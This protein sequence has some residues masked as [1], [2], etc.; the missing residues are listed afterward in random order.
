MVPAFVA[1]IVTL[2]AWPNARL[3]P[4]D[5]PIGVAGE[6]AAAEAVEQQLATQEGAF[7]VHRY[8]DEAEAREAIEDRDVY[9]A[10]V[11]TA[12]G[13]T[14]LTASAA[15]QAVA[16][17]L[18]HEAGDEVYRTSWRHRAVQLW[19]RPSCRSCSREY[20]WASWP[21]CWHRAARSDW[22]CSS[23]CQSYAGSA[24]T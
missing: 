2:F 12:G 8:S 13:V 14:V 20:S 22:A 16:Q 21:R 4:R 19:L 18:S 11:A 10:F 3:E 1:L 24:R 17:L 15:S 6:P 23:S 7:D 5:L 9:G